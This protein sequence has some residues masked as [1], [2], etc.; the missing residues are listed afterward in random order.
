MRYVPQPPY[1][2][3]VCLVGPTFGVS[4]HNGSR[5]FD[6]S[7]TVLEVQAHAQLLAAYELRPTRS[8]ER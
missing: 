6:L 5:V 7:A 3:V 1:D 2:G 4:G 8:L